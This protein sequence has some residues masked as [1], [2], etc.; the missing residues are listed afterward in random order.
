MDL[1]QGSNTRILAGKLS[2]YLKNNYNK[3]SCII[4]DIHGAL[5]S[6]RDLF[7]QIFGHLPRIFLFSLS[8]S[9]MYYEGMTYFVTSNQLENFNFEFDDSLTK[10]NLLKCFLNV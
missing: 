1:Q 4:F 3:D 6:G 5:E 10:F 7:M 2:E 9:N 8:S